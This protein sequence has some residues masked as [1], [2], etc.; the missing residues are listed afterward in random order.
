MFFGI[1]IG[2]NLIPELIKKE[3]PKTEKIIVQIVLYTTL[4]FLILIVLP[5]VGIRFK[6]Q[7]TNTIISL[8]FLISSLIYFAAKKN[9]RNKTISIVIL[10]PLILVG[11]YFQ[12]FH[13]NLGTYKVNDEMNIK[14]SQEGFLACGEIID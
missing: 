3:Y 8:T 9:T 14:I 2:L 6:D 11:F 5:L 13:Q 4:I 12:F 10:L 7:Y 1:L